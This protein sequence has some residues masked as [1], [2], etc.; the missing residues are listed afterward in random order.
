MGDITS[1]EK[2]LLTEEETADLLGKTRPSLADWRF[3]G[4][5]PPYVKLG[6]KVRYRVQSLELWIEA[7]EKT[8]GEH[9]G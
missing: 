3:R 2:N 5:G 6:R 9:H 4:L 1:I 8:A 7:Q